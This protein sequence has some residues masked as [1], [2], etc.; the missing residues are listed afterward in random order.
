MTPAKIN[1]TIYQGADFIKPLQ[2]KTKNP[3]EDIGL[4]TYEPLIAVNLT[5]YSAR[6]QIREKLKDTAFIIELTTA[7]NRIRID[8]AVDGKFSLNINST[9]T[10][11]L[12]F[13]TAVYD[14][15]M[16]DAS[17]IVYR[18]LSGT[19]ALVPEVTRI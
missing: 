14:L 1:L 2:W 16:V 13:K 18:L 17:G 9:D 12:S 8:S 10:A 19:V 7:N 11:A 5:G 6:M 15:E 4:P 3:I